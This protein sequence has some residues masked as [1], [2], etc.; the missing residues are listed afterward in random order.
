[1]LIYNK[2]IKILKY[3]YFTILQEL[4]SYIQ[5]NSTTLY[6][7]IILNIPHK[8]ITRINILG[9]AFIGTIHNIDIK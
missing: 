5:D 4:I 3:I 9:F 7:K 8:Y 2:L 6:S 1:M